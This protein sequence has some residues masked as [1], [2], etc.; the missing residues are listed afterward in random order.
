MIDLYLDFI[1]YIIDDYTKVCVFFKGVNV[2]NFG[3]FGDVLCD[4][5]YYFIL[6]VFDFIKNLG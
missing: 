2:F 5:L 3:F 1:Y 4:F 6:L